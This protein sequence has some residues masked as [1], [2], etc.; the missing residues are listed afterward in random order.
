MPIK[1]VSEMNAGGSLR[2]RINRKTSQKRDFNLL[3]RP[4]YT[5]AVK[6]PCKVT[7]T[8][9]SCRACDDDNLA[10]A[11]KFVRDQLCREIGIDDGSPDISF[12]YKQVRIPKR[13]HYFELEIENL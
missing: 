10:S 4:A 11:F 12:E 1:T 7:F 2:A 13:E 8:R 3:W 9:Y 6:F 5:K